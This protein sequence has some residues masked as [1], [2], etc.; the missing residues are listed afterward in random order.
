VLVISNHVN[1]EWMHIIGLVHRNTKV[2]GF[3]A[4]MKDSLAY[5]P[6]ANCGI[7][8]GF[9]TV[10]RGA[11]K[12]ARA[13]ILESFVRQGARLA[14]DRV[15]LWL[16]IFPEG[17]WITPKDLAVKDKANEFAKKEG[18][19][20]LHNVLYPRA[21]GFCA[22]LKGMCEGEGGGGIDGIDAVYDV[23]VAYN[24]PYH[25][26]RIG[27]AFPP[28]VVQL[29]SADTAA[30][31][32]VHFH[33]TRHA[34]RDIPRKKEEA[35]KWLCRRFAVE[36]ESLLEQFGRSVPHKFPGVDRGSPL[37][38]PSLLIHHTFMLLNLFGVYVVI[39]RMFGTVVVL[40]FLG[41]GAFA[42]MMAAT[43]DKKEDEKKKKK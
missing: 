21:N 3:K 12:E 26:V 28:T 1:S 43:G 13:S 42:A 6:V 2:G 40:I 30:P 25:S 38:L 32:E 29:C 4:V 24:N 10:K 16:V 18:Y 23:T 22:L 33:I 37:H 35:A 34:T 19:P 20:A 31:K 41:L 17:T 39:H 9:V 27:D 11:G 5:V 8:E 7:R 36:K 15:P 14:S